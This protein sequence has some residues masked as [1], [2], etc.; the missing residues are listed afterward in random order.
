MRRKNTQARC[1]DRE[2]SSA[3]KEFFVKF[4]EVNNSLI[5]RNRLIRWLQFKIANVPALKSVA[6]MLFDFVGLRQRSSGESEISR[7][8]NLNLLLPCINQLLVT[9]FAV[10]VNFEM[11]WKA[12]CQ[13]RIP[14]TERTCVPIFFRVLSHLMLCQIVFVAVSSLAHTTKELGR[15]ASFSVLKNN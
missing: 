11:L 7:L 9:I 13:R 10:C 12:V 15:R 6:A 2:T 14:A 8:C 5:V 1:F 4:K 3:R